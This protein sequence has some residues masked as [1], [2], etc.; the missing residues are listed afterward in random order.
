[1]TSHPDNLPEMVFKALYPEFEL[2]AAGMYVVVPAGT[3]VL[4]GD[5]LGHIARQI[6]DRENPPDLGDLLLWEDALPRRHRPS[7]GELEAEAGQFRQSR[8]GA[9]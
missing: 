6:S 8:R 4:T 2:L 3:L 9:G 1:V 7:A 5:S